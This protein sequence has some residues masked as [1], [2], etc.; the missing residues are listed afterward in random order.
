METNRDVAYATAGGRELQLDIYRPDGANALR[1]AVLM[2]HGGGWRAGSRKSLETR[3]ELLQARGF[4]A[5]P[6]EYRLLD[7]AP[8]PAAIEDVRSAIRWTRTHAAE[9]DVDPQRI[10][11]AGFSAGAH[12]G[13]IAAGT[14]ASG[15]GIDG[16]PADLDDTRVAA[17]A[18]FYP[19]TVLHAGET[20][21][22]GSVPASTLLG[23]DAEP[24]AAR[25]ASPVSHVTSDFPPVLL[26]HGGADRRVPT[27]ASVVM[28]EALR[29]AGVPADLHIVAGQNH[30]FD[31]IDA[32]CE[33]LIDEVALFFRRMVSERDAIE[34]QIQE[35]TP[36][37]RSGGRQ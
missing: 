13:L 19:P 36:F 16:D 17:V 18:A 26:I 15:T 23:D 33:V 20:R 2:F 32:F 24:E 31:R 5:S 11:I 27:S 25:R 10:V 7:E 8:W 9:L 22:R 3:A 29:T 6:A 4:T 28:H 30:G 35:Q 14:A 34:R 21:E 12:L 37:A 1:T